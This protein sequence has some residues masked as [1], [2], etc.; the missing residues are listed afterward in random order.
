[1]ETFPQYSPPDDAHLGVNLFAESYGGR[2]GPIFA[3]YFE[4]Q[5]DRRKTGELDAKS[6]VEIKLSTL[7]IVNGCVDQGI[8]NRY[9]PIF[10]NKNTYGFKAISD[11][12]AQYELDKYDSDEGCGKMSKL[13]EEMAEKD[14]PDD[15]GQN[16]QVND[17]CYQAAAV[18]WNTSNGYYAK[19]RSSYDLA[20][21]SEDPRPPL[22]FLEYLNKA[23][24]Q[25][26][27]GTP[28]NYTSFLSLPV[29]Y[30]F[31]ETGDIARAGTI[32]RL[33]SLLKRGVRVGLM[34]G[35][36]D[37]ICNWFGGEA[38]SLAV[39]AQAGGDYAKK[40][41]AAGYSPIVVNKDYVGGEVRQFGNLSFSRIYQAGHSIYAYQPEASF[42][43]FSRIF[44][45][46]SVSTG[47]DIDLS[48]FSSDG[49][50]NSTKTD[51]LP[52]LPKPTCWLR[53]F[54]S[55]CSDEQ[56]QGFFS[57]K[58]VVIN[59]AWYKSEDEFLSR[60]SSADQTTKS[61]PSPTL[62]GGVF[63][64]TSTPKNAAVAFRIP[65]FATLVGVV[66]AG[67]VVV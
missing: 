67:A 30:A 24:V 16:P 45:G 1:M 42:Q 65:S 13:C 2:Y 55:T 15:N 38:V 33:A 57:G 51:K 61:S 9:Y 6:T 19:G 39:A 25:Q 5:N 8:Q 22:S 58:G 37:Y 18:C 63:T 62:T 52:P 36:R 14:D 54:S 46:K 12:E 32:K 43:I 49:P 11:E 17:I 50:L 3:D 28:I 7:G 48:T 41:P 64:A 29:Y 56:Q 21:P 60:L 31:Q 53:S 47:K 27:V 26:A 20:A 23:E 66:I 10:A 4:K 34:Y 35:D 40:F 44:M 59:G